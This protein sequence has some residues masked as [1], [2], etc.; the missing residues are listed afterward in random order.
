MSGRYKK[1]PIIYMVARIQT[2]PLPKLTSDQRASLEQAFVEKGYIDSFISKAQEFN[3]GFPANFEEEEQSNLSVDGKEYLRYGYF[4]GSKQHAFIFDRAAIEFRTTNY[5]KFEDATAIIQSVLD[6]ICEIVPSYRKVLARE[7]VL[8]YVDLIMPYEGRSLSDYFQ[9]NSKILPLSVL[10]AEGEPDVQSFGSVQVTR[11]VEPDKR[12]VVSL[13]QLPPNKD[14]KPSKVL[15]NRLIEQDNV[16]AMPFVKHQE[17]SMSSGYYALLT[18]E[19]GALLNKELGVV[20]F[21]DSSEK[22]HDITSDM[23]KNLINREVC[24]VDWD[25]SGDDV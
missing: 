22:I 14:G 8:I 15:P 6:S 9:A 24:D 17:W 7:L 2:S 3:V 4:H 1:A 21:Y 10:G 5:T 20:N 23:F 12:V 25:Y 16:F 19:S 18:T 13:E 11:I